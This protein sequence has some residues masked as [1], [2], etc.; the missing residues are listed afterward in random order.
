MKKITLL[1]LSTLV[2]ATLFAQHS[3]EVYD[4]QGNVL[5]KARN[6]SAWSPVSKAQPVSILDSVDIQKKAQLRLLDVRTNQLYSSATTGKV[7]VKSI[8]DYAREQDG[9]IIATLNKQLSNNLK[10]QNAETSMSV[11][12]ATTRGDGDGLLDSIAETFIYLAQEVMQGNMPQ[13]NKEL[14]LNR[15]QKDGSLWFSIENRSE[16]NQY[17]NILCIN[18]KQQTVALAYSIQPADNN[19][20]YILLPESESISLKDITFRQSPDVV[21][22][23]V[24]TADA[25]DTYQLSF[26]LLYAHLNRPHQPLYKRYSVNY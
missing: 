21:Y 15:H 9:T 17:V 19:V 8:I 24:A 7:R 12:G 11:L 18:T 2:C 6:T 10:N 5:L 25:Y 16:A 14:V 1:L 22:L 3:Y 23:L 20:P 26:S 13:P 4:W